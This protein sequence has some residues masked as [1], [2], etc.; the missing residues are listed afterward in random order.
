MA[1]DIAPYARKY[2]TEM[3]AYSKRTASAVA[4]R[5]IPAGI[6]VTDID[7]SLYAQSCDEM[8]GAITSGRLIYSEDQPELTTQMLSAARLPFGDGAWIIGRRASQVTV[9]AAVAT[10]LA[11]HFATGSDTEMDIMIAF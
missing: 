3:L 7:G 1:N 4:A 6:P 10:A 11:T 2:Q 9:C 8:L 5:L